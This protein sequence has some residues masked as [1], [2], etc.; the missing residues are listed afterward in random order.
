MSRVQ[1]FPP[2]VSQESKALILGSMPGEA[3]L[4]AGQY[5]AHPRNAFWQIMSE[6]FGA[7][8]SLPYE[9]RV[10]LLRSA[11]IALW[12]TLQAC[13]RPGSLDASITEEAAN[14]FQTFFR[15][16]PNIS[17]VFFNGGRAEAVFRRHVL[18]TLA[19][20]RHTFARLPSTSPAYAAMA[21]ERKVKAWSVVREALDP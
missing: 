18:P 7:G 13:V 6:L 17:D 14:D 3:S 21:L 2:I 9:E 11:G 20:C 16:H 10:A 4:K 5:Y 1:S 19:E 15:N 12:D 8:L